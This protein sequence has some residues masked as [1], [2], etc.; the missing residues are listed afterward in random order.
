MKAKNK[1]AIK[2]TAI[3]QTNNKMW[4][5]GSQSASYKKSTQEG[6][7]NAHGMV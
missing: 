1:Q 6:G 4:I 2:N 7:E 5:N 3:M